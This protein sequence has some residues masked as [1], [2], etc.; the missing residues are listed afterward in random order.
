M[1]VTADI[2]P[3][4]AWSTIAATAP[5]EQKMGK[6]VADVTGAT[7]STGV[8]T[9]AHAKT[10]TTCAAEGVMP[11]CGIRLVLNSGID[12][13][14]PTTGGQAEETDRDSRVRLLGRTASPGGWL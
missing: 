14:V 4:D 1:A 3:K 10:M 7:V 11:T 8:S 5:V 12:A 9:T 13:V 6:Y 2:A